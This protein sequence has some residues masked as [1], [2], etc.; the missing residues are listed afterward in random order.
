MKYKVVRS[1][2]VA[3]QDFGYIKVKQLLN[4]KDVDNVSVSLVTINGTNKRIINKRGDALYYVIEGSGSFNIEGE[5][6]Q[7]EV[8]DL[9]YI[10]KGTPYF[11]K[12]NLVMLSVNTP[13]FDKDFIDYLN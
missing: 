13:R 3:E 2:E 7:V 9:V 12:G 10:P 8:G 5:E 6:L 1:K 11:D 4:Q